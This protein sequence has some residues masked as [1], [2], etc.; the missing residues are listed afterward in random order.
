MKLLFDENLSPRLVGLL[1]AEYPDS[2]HVE[3][4]L[5]RGRADADLWQYAATH[6]YAIISK[7]SDLRQRA[8]VSGPPPKVIWLSVGNAG[9]DDILRLIRASLAEINR[10]GDART[11]ALLVLEL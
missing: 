5:G 4:A 6:G 3:Q 7:D 11:E 1:A 2:T 10:F 8:F 9:T